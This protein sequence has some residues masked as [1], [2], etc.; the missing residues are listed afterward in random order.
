MRVRVDGHVQ[1]DALE[2]I[3]SHLSKQRT[4]VVARAHKK[5]SPT[6]AARPS[7]RNDWARAY[8]SMTHQEPMHR[9]SEVDHMPPQAP[10]EQVQG[11]HGAYASMTASGA[12]AIRSKC[13]DCHRHAPY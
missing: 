9:V 12:D 11:M 1:L 4:E 8:A 5:S 6:S 13:K 3:A 7:A 2:P 10:Q